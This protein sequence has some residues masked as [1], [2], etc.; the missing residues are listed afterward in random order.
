MRVATLASLFVASVLWFALAS[1]P[2][3]SQADQ[4]TTKCE[5]CAKASGSCPHCAAGEDCPHCSKGKECPHCA[6]AKTCAHCGHRGHHGHHGKWGGHQWEYKC[7]RPAKKPAEMTKQFTALGA[8]RWRLAEA[9]GGVWCFS[10]VKH[11]K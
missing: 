8:E 3:P 4:H 10:R 1:V 5:T 9:H 7:V 6:K 2:A 11:S